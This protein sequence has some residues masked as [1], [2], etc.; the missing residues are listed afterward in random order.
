VAA[1]RCAAR[2]LAWAAD[3]GPRAPRF[4][5]ARAVFA[6]PVP[7]RLGGAAAPCASDYARDRASVAPAPVVAPGASHSMDG[8]AAA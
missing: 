5:S 6:A 7:G 3:A 2:A 8:V 4:G 1:E